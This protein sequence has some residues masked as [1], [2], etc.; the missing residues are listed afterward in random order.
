[1]TDRRRSGTL[2]GVPRST[3]LLRDLAAR[4]AALEERMARLERGRP[5]PGDG[6][7]TRSEPPPRRAVARCPGCGLPLRR[8]RGRCAACGRPVD[9]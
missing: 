6:R 5:P 8:R 2:A 1:L 3:T 9:A 4:V 7:T